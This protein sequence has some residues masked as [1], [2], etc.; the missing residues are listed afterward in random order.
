MTSATHLRSMVLGLCLAVCFYVAGCGGGS[1]ATVPPQQGNGQL[2]G[3]VGDI[4]NPPALGDLPQAQ[5][6]TGTSNGAAPLGTDPRYNVELLDAAETIFEPDHSASVVVGAPPAVELADVV[7]M[8][9]NV[10]ADFTLS[11]GTFAEG[12]QVDI[13]AKYKVN[14]PGDFRRYW[15]SPQIYLDFTEDPVNHSGTGTYSVKIDYVIP[16]GTSG[17]G[18][19]LDFTVSNADVAA[20][21]PTFT[22]DITA[23]SGGT[24]RALY[25]ADTDN[26]ND[27]QGGGCKP[28]WITVTFDTATKVTCS[29]EKDLSNVVFRY[30][31]GTTYKFD[32]LSV[33]QTFQFTSP[34]A[35]ASKTIQGVWVKTGCNAT[36]DGPGFGEYFDNQNGEDFRVAFAQ[37]GWEDLLV[38]ADYDYNDFVGRMNCIEFRNSAGNLVQ[39]QFTI[40][41]VA[42]AAGYDA[43]WQFNINGAFPGATATAI[44][45][46]FYTS[47]E[48]HD[49]QK[50]WRSTSGASVPV[51]TPLSGALPSPDGTLG[52]N[53][54]PG[55]TYVDGDYAEVTIVFDTPV[56]AGTY[57]PMPY[58][59]QLRV[60]AN[61]GNVYVIDMW[62]QKGDW[63]DSN[64]RPLAF[65]VPDTYAWPLE[66]KQIWNVYEG[67]FNT[68]INYL[69]STNG[70]APFPSW[71]NT[72]PAKDYF[73]REL[74]N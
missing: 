43:D 65:I 45:D 67:D 33:G 27:T 31:D 25:P 21:A 62:K 57:T 6:L 49:F 66:G 38:N 74:F 59:P 28:A 34:P 53:G 68:W 48:R 14:I 39:I 54:V 55:T 64:G 3:T 2:P 70:T 9:N 46:Q 22:Y 15:E 20:E 24:T 41:A 17:T 4:G 1:S 26:T 50:I 52:P 37:M 63:L 30:S 44:V 29:S 10:A 19:P 56:A 5:A 51:F 69:N 73:R 40:K 12:A 7:M 13:W 23:I 16:Y 58:E 35:Y 72:A 60:E 18:F 36:G 61:G 8:A 11:S 47:G 42:R 32:N 71:W